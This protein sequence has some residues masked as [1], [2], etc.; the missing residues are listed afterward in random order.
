MYTSTGFQPS[1]RI[2]T[3]VIQ[4]VA[5]ASFDI[6]R[7]TY[8]QLTHRLAVAVG[9]VF[10]ITYSFSHKKRETESSSS[11]SRLLLCPVQLACSLQIPYLG[12]HCK[13]SGA[14]EFIPKSRRSLVAA[15]A[16]SN[17]VDLLSL[18]NKPNAKKGV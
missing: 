3:N 14:E 10:C 5:A 17:S 8:L 13:F 16:E 2:R 11:S 6:G 7:V 4:T 1:H 12:W 18:M 15:A 9:A